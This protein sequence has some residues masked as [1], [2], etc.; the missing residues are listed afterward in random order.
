MGYA[1]VGA[2]LFEQLESAYEIEQRNNKQ[3][4]WTSTFREIRQHYVTELWNITGK[5]NTKFLW[6]YISKLKVKE[7]Y[8]MVSVKSNYKN[9]LRHVKEH[10]NE[11][12][13]DFHLGLVIV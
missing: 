10:K 12:K 2:A 5:L 13:E 4:N 9:R 3:K 8:K 1:I 7:R 11:T 6:K